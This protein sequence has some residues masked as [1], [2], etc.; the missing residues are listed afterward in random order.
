VAAGE[1]AAGSVGG[2][3]VAVFDAVASGAGMGEAGGRERTGA[4]GVA[5]PDGRVQAARLNIVRTRRMIRNGF[6]IAKL[7]RGK[8]V[9]DH[10]E[11]EQ[12]TFGHLI[13]VTP[14]CAWRFRPG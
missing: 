3:S 11:E 10:P 13:H 2:I 14:G 5:S 12:G 7:L 4:V 9:T 1:L 8:G 6:G